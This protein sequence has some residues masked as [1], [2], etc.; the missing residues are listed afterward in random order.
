MIVL[1]EKKRERVDIYGVQ[2]FYGRV[3]NLYMILVMHGYPWN[4][5]V[6]VEQFSLI[7]QLINTTNMDFVTK[8]HSRMNITIKISLSLKVH[9]DFSS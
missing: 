5:S 3:R 4:Q 1:T 9:E 2:D 8:L 7:E 6:M